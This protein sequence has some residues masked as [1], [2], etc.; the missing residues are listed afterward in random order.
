M[1]GRL[2]S[3]LKLST[4]KWLEIKNW[5]NPNSLSCSWIGKNQQRAVILLE[6]FKHSGCYDRPWETRGIIINYVL[7]AAIIPRFR[8]SD[9]DSD[10]IPTVVHNSNDCERV[11]SVAVG[12]HWPKRVHAPTCGHEWVPTV[13]YSSVYDR[14]NSSGF[15]RELDYITYAQ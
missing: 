12:H 13:Y 9:D 15:F 2:A 8:H 1:I 11:F 10:G 14:E 6:H 3:I 5:E 4:Q 7:I